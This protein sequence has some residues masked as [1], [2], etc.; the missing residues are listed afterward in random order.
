MLAERQARPGQL[1]DQDNLVQPGQAA[2]AVLLRPG[3]AE[4]A[5]AVQGLPPLRREPVGRRAL[6]DGPDAGPVRR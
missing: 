5:S 1:L 6:G 2:P 4:Q 3:D